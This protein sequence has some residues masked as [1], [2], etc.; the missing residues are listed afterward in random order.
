MKNQEQI[1]TKIQQWF[2]DNISLIAIVIM[3][4]VYIFFGVIEIK[5]R[6]TNVWEIFAS[7]GLSFAYGFLIKTLLNNQGLT[8]GEKSENFIKTRSFYLSLLDDISDYDHYLE[9]Y[10]DELNEEN[11]KKAQTSILKSHLLK[12]EDFINN[13]INVDKLDKGQKKA[14]YKARNLKINLLSEAIL[15]SDQEYFIENGEDLSPTRKKYMKT[16]T[17]NTLIIMI[18]TA[19]LF[20]YY[21]IDKNEGFNWI[22]AVWSLIQVAYYLG[23]GTVQYFQGYTFMTDTYRNIL[24]R[25]SNYIEKFKNLYK[26]NPNRFKTKEEIIVEKEK[27]KIIKNLEVKNEQCS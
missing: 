26:E 16:S 22:G 15:L 1:T 7:C 23:F 25:K 4:L 13:K 12:Y 24:I 21:G 11:I 2:K 6:D 17:R 18:C 14:Y 27:E 20:G 3:S 10:C 9:R 8:N 19:F 5:D